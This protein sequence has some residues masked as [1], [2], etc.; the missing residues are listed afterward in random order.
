MWLTSWP[1]A[2]ARCTAWWIGPKVEPQPTTASLPLGVAERDVLLR[3][4]VG[5]AVDLGERVS[6][7]FWWL[8]ARS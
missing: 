3:N 7:I 1:C 2:R 5:D 4:V 8:P 6:V